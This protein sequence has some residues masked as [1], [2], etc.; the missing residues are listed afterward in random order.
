MPLFM[1][2]VELSHTLQSVNDLDGKE[3]ERALLYVYLNA[4]FETG[5]LSPIDAAIC[6]HCVIDIAAWKK[7]DEVPYD[8]VRKRLTVVVSG[9]EG[10]LMITKGALAQVLEVCATAEDASGTET[11][12]ESVRKQIE[13]RFAQY[14]KSGQR[15]LGLA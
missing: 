2:H 8:F 4:S 12:L 14:S 13:T 3:S 7:L 5:F 9:P 6:H 1:Q 10:T 11:P 15:T